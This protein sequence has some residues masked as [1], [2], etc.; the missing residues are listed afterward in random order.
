MAIDER[1]DIW[2]AWVEQAR[3]RVLLQRFGPDVRPRFAPAVDVSRMPR[4]FSWLPRIAL[5][6]GDARQVAV[7]WQEIVFSGGSHGGEIFVA[8]S[9]DG[10]RSFAAPINLSRSRAGDGKGRLRHDH[11]HNGSLDIALAADG[12]VHAAWTDYEGALWFSRS[13]GAGGGFSAP[14]RIPSTAV[15]RAPSLAVARDGTVYLAWTHGEQAQADVQL[16][17][18]SD[19]G[20]SFAVPVVV[21]ATP[22][23]S[24]A[25]KLALDAQG[26]LHIAYSE[27]SRG[28][29]GPRRIEYLRSR[30]GARSFEAPRVI[31]GTP[32]GS[33]PHLAAAGG[34][35]V[36]AWEV[37][38]GDPQLPTRGLAFSVSLDGGD[39]FTPPAVVPGSADP[40]GGDNG[41]TQGLLM[42]KLALN[43]Q[44]AVA[45]V[46]S[47]LKPGSHS[48]VWLVRGQL[49]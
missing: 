29:F 49:P 16:A 38:A 24:D 4:T 31:S 8:R 20:R 34:R 26:V 1:G 27:G 46:N 21:A 30:D 3:K 12:S 33:Y 35:V 37:Q 45:V 23:H 32:P 22:G 13:Q 9:S 6:P 18:S 36:L 10:G 41:S 39:R 40:G 5:R 43:A 42:R 44:G 28:P 2:V 25:P 17:R 19:G 47:S 15:A 48:R 7:L 11:W 14:Q